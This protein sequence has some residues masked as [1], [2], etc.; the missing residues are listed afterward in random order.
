MLELQHLSCYYSISFPSVL[1]LL[2]GNSAAF[3]LLGKG[4]GGVL[5]PVKNFLIPLPRI[6]LSNIFYNPTKTVF[7]RKLF[8]EL[9]QH[10][11]SY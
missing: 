6:P 9:Y 7:H 5:P 2:L 8:L 11:S 10:L 4:K 1:K 3:S